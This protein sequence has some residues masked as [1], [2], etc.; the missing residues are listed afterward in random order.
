MVL[1]YHNHLFIIHNIT[2]WFFFYFFFN[3]FSHNNLIKDCYLFILIHHIQLYHLL[4]L[5]ILLYLNRFVYLICLF[6]QSYLPTLVIFIIWIL[7]ICLFLIVYLFGLYF[8]DLLNY[9]QINHQNHFHPFSLYFLLILILY[10][11][12]FLIFLYYL[13]FLKV[14]T[15]KYLW[16]LLKLN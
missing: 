10:Y 1:L 6:L 9:L 16:H 4:S 13:Y 11:L 7:V 15:I 8:K 12:F 2:Y 3:W 5:K 14:I